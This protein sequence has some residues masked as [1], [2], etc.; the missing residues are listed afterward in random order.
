MAACTDWNESFNAGKEG[1]TWPEN[2]FLSPFLQKSKEMAT[3]GDAVDFL[4]PNLEAAML[5]MNELEL[6]LCKPLWRFSHRCSDK[7]Q[8][9]ADHPCYAALRI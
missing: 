5:W 2:C 7:D 4:Q 6:E 3:H 9:I 1:L 8:W